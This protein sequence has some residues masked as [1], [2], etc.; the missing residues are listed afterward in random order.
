MAL[1][2]EKELNH[3]TKLPDRAV[4][5]DNLIRG[6]IQKESSNLQLID[7]IILTKRFVQEHT[8]FSYTRYSFF[9]NNLH[10]QDRGLLA[11]IA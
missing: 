3:A 1:C 10:K 4:F 9:D 2:N 7:C 5:T 11:I 8:L 6:I